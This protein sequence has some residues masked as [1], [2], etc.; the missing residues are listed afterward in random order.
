MALEQAIVLFVASAYFF[1]R[2]LA[3]EGRADAFRYRPLVLGL[4]AAALYD[5]SVG[6]AGFEPATSCSQS[7][8]SNQA[9]L[10]PESVPQV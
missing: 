3:G 7:K 10:H 6:V 5:L 1:L 4:V 8:H 2:F 9:E